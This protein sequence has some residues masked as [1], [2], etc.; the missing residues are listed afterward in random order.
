MKD[1]FSQ[2]ASAQLLLA[3]RLVFEGLLILGLVKSFC[4]FKVFCYA[5]YLDGR[6][7]A[8]SLLSLN[9]SSRARVIADL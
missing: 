2:R 9:I 6:C 3:E 5:I 4:I 7:R 1:V 8:W